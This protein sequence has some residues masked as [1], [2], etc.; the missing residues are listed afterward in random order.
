MCLS[1]FWRLNECIITSYVGDSVYCSD[2]TLIEINMWAPS[3]GSKS[4]V[5]PKVTSYLTITPIMF[6]E[7]KKCGFPHHF[8]CVYTKNNCVYRKFSWINNCLH[9]EFN[10]SNLSL[11]VSSFIVT[12]C[13]ETIKNKENPAFDHEPFVSSALL[14]VYNTQVKVRPAWFTLPAPSI[15]LSVRLFPP[16]CLTG[17]FSSFDLSVQEEKKQKQNI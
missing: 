7:K 15:R 2:E 17:H 8:S 6:R 13:Q 4:E 1:L 12:T 5:T 11:S 10:N 16:C 14:Q 9:G 3:V